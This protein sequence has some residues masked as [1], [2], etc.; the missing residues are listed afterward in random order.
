MAWGT[1]RPI[2]IYCDSRNIR[3]SQTPYIRGVILVAEVVKHY[4]PDMR[5]PRHFASPSTKTMP[6]TFLS[7]PDSAGSLATDRLWSLEEIAALGDQ[8]SN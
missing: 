4:L 8:E 7:I 6:A 3:N 2:A 5:Y 1:G